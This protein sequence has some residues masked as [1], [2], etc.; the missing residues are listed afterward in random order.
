VETSNA[1]LRLLFS[2]AQA[3]KHFRVCD[4]GAVRIGNLRDEN[5]KTIDSSWTK[6][7]VTKQSRA[8]DSDPWLVEVFLPVPDKLRT[9]PQYV[10]AIFTFTLQGEVLEVERLGLDEGLQIQKDIN[11]Q[12]K[13]PGA[14]PVV[15]ITDSDKKKRARATTVIQEIYMGQFEVSDAAVNLA[16]MSLR[17]QSDEG[18]QDILQQLELNVDAL[19]KSLVDECTRQ[20]DDLALRMSQLG[21]DLNSQLQLWQLPSELLGSASGGGN[22][23]DPE[24]LK[25]RLAELEKLYAQAQ[26]RIKWLEGTRDT[27]YRSQ[28]Q[29]AVLRRQMIEKKKGG[30][31]DA[32]SKVCV[33]S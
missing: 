5:D 28:Q 12:M 23:D 6:L 1:E 10:D 20:Y 11:L 31:S 27:T 25:K 21:I 2:I 26:E 16:M 8:S 4:V 3:D 32:Q 18:A 9:D 22:A 19:K 14:A 7:Q 30:A 15:D 24:T 17:D 13:K 29:I 33:I